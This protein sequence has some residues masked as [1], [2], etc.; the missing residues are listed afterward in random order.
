MHHGRSS[1]KQR[2]NKTFVSMVC[3]YGLLF[4]LCYFANNMLVLNHILQIPDVAMKYFILSILQIANKWNN[5]I[6][7]SYD[8]NNQTNWSTRKSKKPLTPPTHTLTHTYLCMHKH[9]SCIVLYSIVFFQPVDQIALSRVEYDDLSVYNLNV[10]GSNQFPQLI[11][12]QS[13]HSF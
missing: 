10:N 9:Y 12:H 8:N 6:T 2:K 11:A 4:F 7:I 1:F 3:I 13:L 5:V